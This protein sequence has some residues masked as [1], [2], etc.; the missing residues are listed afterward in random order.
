MHLIIDLKLSL[1]IF[2]K[3]IDDALMND[4]FLVKDATIASVNPYI[5]KDFD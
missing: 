4:I 2:W 5:F 1:M 3:S